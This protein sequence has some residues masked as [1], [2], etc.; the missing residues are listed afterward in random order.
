MLFQNII[1]ILLIEDEVYDVRRV[2]KTLEPFRDRLKIKKVVADGQSALDALTG[3]KS[4]YDVIIMDYQIVGGI[5]G[6]A[7]IR[8][9]RE[10]DD[11]LQII[12]ITKMTINISDFDFANRLIEAGAMW[13]CTKYPG[14]IED[15]IYQPTDFV[16][17]ILNA[18]E[19][20]RLE[21]ERKKSTRKLSQNIEEALAQKQ[22]IG[23]SEEIN[24]LRDQIQRLAK[25][26]TTVL[27]SGESGTGKELI[28]NH[29]HFNS[30]RRFEKMVAINCGSLP[31]EL[32]E[33]ELFG[34]EK[35]SFTGAHVQK[36]GLFEVANRGTVFLD[37]VG[38]LPLSA[39]VKLLR[40]LQEGE[41]DKI[42]RTEKMKVDV[43]II[44]A[45]NKNLH[46]AVE[47]KKF[48]EDL[49]YRLNVVNLHVPP[50]RERRG[51][52]RLFFRYFL[53]K[54]AQQFNLPVP[55]V[56]TSAIE[57]ITEFDWPGNVRQLQ[58]VIHRLLVLGRS[59]IDQ[60]QIRQALG[61][62][63]AGESKR[64]ASSL[65]QIWQNYQVG[66]WRDVEKKLK[67]DYFRYVRD[68]TA[69]DA[70]AAR[71]LGL[72]PPNYYRMCKELGLK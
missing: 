4:S 44:A 68:N 13:Y 53:E 58:N 5:S 11:T 50:L 69:S 48:R 60:L 63:P 57:F 41:I 35:G 59:P 17:S 32:I 64:A 72:A 39:Q 12:V 25:I 66:S 40:V 45:T 15:F 20:R 10:I 47:E 43:R 54:F 6:E 71:R 61:L 29:I 19:K 55:E 14:D 21:K 52:I 56:E 42:G 33:S 8:R 1:N 34:F 26:D 67:Y 49:Y 37:E 24:E 3:S 51:D 70:E 30:Q 27:I 62:Q 2:E 46:Q 18:Y 31:H 38:E 9:I 36:P 16:L 28:A 65:Q 22:L 7:L 23:E